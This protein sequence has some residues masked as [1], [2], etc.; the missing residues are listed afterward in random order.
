[1]G[2]PM[3][4]RV[5]DMVGGVRV[6]VVVEGLGGS[7]AGYVRGAG[8]GPVIEAMGAALMVLEVEVFRLGVRLVEGAG[9]EGS[10][11]VGEEMVLV[12]LVT[13]KVVREPE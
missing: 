4:L 8:L 9:V 6:L 3:S 2:L 10:A 5:A 13:V 7:W 1:M 11:V 12:F